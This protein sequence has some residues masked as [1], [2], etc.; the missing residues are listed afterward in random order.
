M[1]DGVTSDPRRAVRAALALPLTLSLALALALAAGVSRADDR[2]RIDPATGLIEPP[3]SCAAIAAAART[4]VT[5]AASAPRMVVGQGRLQFFSAPDQRCTAPGLFV[6][7]G[8]SLVVKAELGPF[9]FAEYTNPRTH[10]QVS[11][12]VRSDRLALVMDEKD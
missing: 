11:G 3:S 2:P 8:D 6:V 12:W 5:A 9:A 1:G 4:H 7:P 10:A